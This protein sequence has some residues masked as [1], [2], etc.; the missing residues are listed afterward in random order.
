MHSVQILAPPTLAA[1]PRRQRRTVALV[2]AFVVAAL[3]ITLTMA[4]APA[5]AAVTSGAL[6][7]GRTPTGLLTHSDTR[8]I[9]VGTKFSVVTSGVAS[10]V[11]FYKTSRNTGTHVGSLWTEQGTK[12]ASVTFSG[13]TAT[14][15]QTAN[16]AKPVTLQAGKRYVVSYFA[17]KGQQA[18]KRNLSVASL[19]SALSFNSQA[20][21][22]RFGSKSVFPAYTSSLKSQFFVDVVFTPNKTAAPTTPAGFPSASTTGVPAGTTLSAYTGPCTIT[23]AGAVIDAKTINCSSLSIRAAGVKITRSQLN[24]TVYAGTDGS[25]SFTISDST[26]NVGDRMGTGIGDAHF[27]ATR[28]HV[29]GGNRSINCFLKCTVQSSYVHGQFRDETG[30]AHESGIRI[31]SNSTIRGNTIACDAP[32]VPPDAGCS[33]ALTGYG[34]FAVV[35]DNV[36]DGNLFLPTTGGFCAYGGSTTGKPYSAGVNDIKFTNN[37]F[38]RGSGGK[39]GYWGA[40]TSFDVNAPGNVWSNNKW[41]D[42]AL[43]APSN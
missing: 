20:G 25:G 12:L 31:G 40:I 9:E 10:G 5:R 39:C 23:T 7:G 36:I 34:D 15:W 8:A 1:P 32:D 28:V 41:S 26:V 4:A 33:A 22:Y 14:G 37:V 6:F 17:P 18:V 35:Q 30:T 42:G 27:T 38:T 24:G 13:E 21:V 19:S 2:V 11:S 3:I 16:F 29:T 43:L